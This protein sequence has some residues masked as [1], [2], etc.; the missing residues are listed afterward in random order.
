[1]SR[2]T[3]GNREKEERGKMEGG[4]QISEGRNR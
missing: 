1:M 3:Q 2:M 4:D